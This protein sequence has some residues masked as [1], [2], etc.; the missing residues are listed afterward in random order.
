[1]MNKLKNNY[2]LKEPMR[3]NKITKKNAPDFI[4]VLK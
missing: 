3:K 1:M 4:E 2:N